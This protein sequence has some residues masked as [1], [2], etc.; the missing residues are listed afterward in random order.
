MSCNFQ[1]INEH[2]C[3][4][5]RPVRPA[6][7]IICLYVREFIGLPPNNGERIMTRLAGKFTP[8]LNVLVATIIFNAPILK[9]FSIM[10]RSSVVRPA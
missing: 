7:P 8:E 4:R 10:S 6:R 1:V 5:T 9:P 2:L 3:G